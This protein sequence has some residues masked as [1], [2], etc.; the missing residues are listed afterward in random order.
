MLLNKNLIYFYEVA[1][2]GSIRLAADRLH[3]SP[4]SISRMISQLE[5]Y[6]DT[7]LFERKSNGMYLTPSGNL[8]FNE[9]HIINTHIDDIKI[10]I[11]E[12]RGLRRGEVTLFCIEAIMPYIAPKFLKQF[13]RNNPNITFTVEYGST[14]KIVKALLNYTADIGITFNMPNTKNIHKLKTFKYPLYAL[15]APNHPLASRAELSL[16]DVIKYRIV[17]PKKSFGVRRI[18]DQ[19]LAQCSLDPRILVTTNSLVFARG[20]ARTG[21]ALTFSSLYTAKAELSMGQLIA[22]PLIEHELL[23]GE[24]AICKHSE[25]QLTTAANELLKYIKNSFVINSK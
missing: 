17:V 20:L 7:I 18:I 19:A 8:L 15:V 6:F 11:D 9:L 2:C 22:I 12:L 25:R 24:T 13:N 23:I 21:L 14:D 1:Q 3:I 5:Y 16:Y 4:S 10:S